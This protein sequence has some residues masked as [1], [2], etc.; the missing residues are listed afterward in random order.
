MYIY[1][2][3]YLYIC[4]HIY[5]HICAYI[6]IHTH[7]YIQAVCSAVVGIF[8][9]IHNDQTLFHFHLL[10]FVV[11][12]NA[13]EPLW[14]K[15]ALNICKRA[16]VYLPNNV[17]NIQSKHA[18]LLRQVFAVFDLRHFWSSTSVSVSVC[19]SLSMCLCLSVSVSISLWF[20]FC[21]SL[22]LSLSPLCLLSV[23]CLSLSLYH[24]PNIF[25]AVAA[26]RSFSFPPSLPPHLALLWSQASFTSVSF[27]Q[28]IGDNETDGRV[29][30]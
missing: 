3:M 17:G 25:D 24:S 26:A 13:K 16:L 7:I 5:I 12:Y 22:S 10:I 19:L 27:S 21:L 6:H 9:L 2:F 8:S 30:S 15:R 1:I 11:L 14:T 23:S 29:R 4:T 28:L 18:L 20:Y